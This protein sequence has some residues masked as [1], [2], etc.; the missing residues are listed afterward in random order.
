MVVIDQ[1]GGL[2]WIEAI[3]GNRATVVTGADRVIT[4]TLGRPGIFMGCA[5]AVDANNNDMAESGIIV[6]TDGTELIPGTFISAVRFE[7]ENNAGA[8]REI[9]CNVIVFM[10]K[11]GSGE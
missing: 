5:L 6:E 4:L 1:Q 8:D 9:G 2:F 7:M 3:H 10:R 11:R